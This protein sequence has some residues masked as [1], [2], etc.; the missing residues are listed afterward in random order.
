MILMMVMMIVLVVMMVIMI[1][2]VIVIVTV[3]TMTMT[4]TMMIFLAVDSSVSDGF[5]DIEPFFWVVFW[6][7][8]G[9]NTEK[10]ITMTL[11][12]NSP[13]SFV[14]GS[15]CRPCLREATWNAVTKTHFHFS[16]NYFLLISPYFH[17][18]VLISIDFSSLSLQVEEAMWYA[19]AHC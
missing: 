2:I 4:M 1:M 7:N 6:H 12:Q 16:L 13:S 15:R 14:R 3:L 17:S 10:M 9:D 5:H 18:F 8:F 11:P 19:L